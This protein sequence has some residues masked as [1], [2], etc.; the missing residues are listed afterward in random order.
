MKPVDY[1]NET[2]AAMHG[3]VVGLRLTVY[4]ALLRVGP[5]TT[6]QLASK[7]GVDILTVRPRIT[8]LFQIGW[9]ELVDED[10]GGNEGEYRALSEDA[11]KSVFEKRRAAAVGTRVQAELPL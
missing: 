10:A 4:E 6:R 5:C 3:R 1:R 7:S 11:A 8:E 2:W 9:V